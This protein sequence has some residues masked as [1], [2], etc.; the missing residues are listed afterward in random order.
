M[1]NNMDLPLT[2]NDI[3]NSS[4]G[5]EIM[6]LYQNVTVTTYDVIFRN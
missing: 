2:S 5:C 1:E 6:L 3:E 4:L